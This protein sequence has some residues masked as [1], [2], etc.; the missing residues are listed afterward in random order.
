M[1]SKIINIAINEDMIKFSADHILSIKNNGDFSDTAF[2]MPSKRPSLFIKKELSEKINKSF[3]PP[4]FF[5]F[6]E[7]VND[8]AKNYYN[9]RKISQIDSAYAIFET[10]KKNTP[11]FFEEHTSFAGF[12]Q[13]S[14]EILAFIE[15]LDIEKIQNDK[16]LNIKLNADIGYDLP[17]NINELLK[18]LSFIRMEFHKY[19]LSSKKTTRGYAYFLADSKISEYLQKYKNVILFNPYYLNKSE[20]DMFKKIYDENKL[21]I[22]IKG[23]K[24]NW[25][26]IDKMYKDF[27]VTPSKNQNQEKIKGKI[28]FYCAYDGES[29]AC[30]AK[31]LLSK[32]PQN[33]IKDT[34]I[35]VPDNSILPSVMS[36]AYSII[37]DINVAVGYPA[38]KTTVF[39]LINAVLTAQKNRKNDKYYVKD[40]IS[41]LANP[42]AKN[43]RFIGNPSVTR[44][45]VHTIMQHF[46]RFNQEAEFKEYQFIDPDEI[47]NNMK[48]Q[49]EVSRT[50]SLYWQTVSPNRVSE[51]LNEIFDLFFYRP[52]HISN[53]ADMGSYLKYIS[54]IIVEKSFIKTYPFNLGAINI[55]YDIAG[56]FEKAVCTNEKFEQYEIFYIL[57]E[58]LLKG[59]ISL[60]GSP[61]KGLQIL[62]TMETR[63]ISF[64]NV[65]ILSM[66]DS[67]MPSI[68]ETSPLIPKDIMNSLGIGYIS[69]ETDIQKYHFMSLIASAENVTLIYPDDEKNGRSR[70]IEELIWKE[71]SEKKS[72]KVANVIKAVLSNKT[73]LNN[74]QEFSKTDK[75]KDFLKNFSYSPTSIDTYLRC[76]LQFYFKYI[77][78]LAEQTDFEQNYEK[79]NIGNFIHEFLEETFYKGLNKST[80]TYQNFKEY[81]ILLDKKLEYYFKQHETGKI[82]LLKKLIKKRLCDFYENEQKQNFK[83]ILEAEA[84]F[85]SKIK[86]ADGIYNLKLK[87]DRIDKNEDDSLYVIDYKTG[88]IETPLKAKLNGEIKGDQREFIQKNIKSFQLPVYKFVYEQENPGRTIANCIL[89]SIRDCKKTYLFDT[90]M[91]VED[92]QNIYNICLEQLKY[93]ITEINSEIPFKSEPYDKVKCE[94]CPYFYLCR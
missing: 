13:W 87:I 88:S 33:D 86:T 23:D 51:I 54:D 77:L 78:Q 24:N 93:I 81:K 59:N 15:S 40:I 90:K 19:L 85:T 22:I 80:L 94:V 1:A 31:N 18:N 43:M 82:F 57:E 26:S 10:V 76:K 64:K 35:I 41:V 12:F 6:D 42:L 61:L 52:Q 60:V 3:I 5:T 92:K 46:D 55:L 38:K 62:G 67:V 27:N 63:G 49:K 74:K 2:I 75:I 68:K 47:K 71:Q 89:Y 66:S 30:L 36:Q 39:S 37:D 9:L 21:D 11:K 79:L 4:V 69:R 20:T 17:K 58:I 48:L 50:V 72:L 44:I 14:Y 83:E 28:N 91:S 7:L 45:I 16:L 53:M 8:I 34:V 70:F 32:I 65:Y 73:I 84:K 25:V 29:Q 56:Q